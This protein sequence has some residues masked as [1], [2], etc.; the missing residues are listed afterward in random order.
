M[1]EKQ[2][3]KPASIAEFGPVQLVQLGQ[4]KAE[5]LLDLQRDL[6]DACDEANRDWA[7]RFKSEVKLWSEFATKLVAAQTIPELAEA[8]GECLSQRAQ[9]A[10]EDGQLLLAEGQKIIATVTGALSGR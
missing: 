10:A 5:T 6:L 8:Y 9:L 2:V 7:T 4:K 1:V 3:D